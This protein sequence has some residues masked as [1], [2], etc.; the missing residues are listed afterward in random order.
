MTKR[1]ILGVST[2]VL[3]AGVGLGAAQLAQAETASP[4]PTPTTS[5][6]ATAPSQDQGHGGRH[7][8]GGFRDV[9]GLAE[10]LGV[11]ETTLRD[12]IDKV[13]GAASEDREADRSARE[14]AFAQALAEALGIDESKV[15]AAL[16]ELRSEREAART[17]SDKEVLDKAVTDGTL[18]QAEADAVAKAVEEGIVR[19]RGGDHSR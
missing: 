11:E 9:S 7:G 2:A 10:K 3:A 13:R 1:I 5:A 14:A 4:S 6:G 17:A 19:V 18:T 12:A 16:D 8:R 15:T